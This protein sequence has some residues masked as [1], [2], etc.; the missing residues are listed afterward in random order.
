MSNKSNDRQAL[1]TSS[2]IKT[3]NFNINKNKWKNKK[4]LFAS[5]LFTVILIVSVYFITA[6][7]KDLWPFQ[8]ESSKHSPNKPNIIY[9]LM[10]NL[11][12]TDVGYNGASFVTP[13]IDYLSNNGIKLNYHYA[14]HICSAS[15]SAL[16]TGRY[17]WKTTLNAVIQPYQQLH[18]NINTTTFAEELQKYGFYTLLSGKW[19]VGG[20]K[21]D[22]MPFN[23]GFNESLFF[24]SGFEGYYS[25]SI[26]VP[27]QLIDANANLS[28]Q[29]KNDRNELFGDSFCAYDLFDESMNTIHI[30]QSIYNEQLFADKI[31]KFIDENS[32]N[33][34]T[35]NEP[36]FIY[37]SMPT[38]HSPVTQP[39]IQSELCGHLYSINP[40]RA[41]L[42]NMMQFGDIM[43]SQ[44][45]QKLKQNN[46]YNDTIIMF[47]SDNGPQSI[48]LFG[49][50]GQFG[51][52]LPLRGKIRTAFEG[53]VR[54]SAVIAG[55]YIE[56]I[57]NYTGCSYNGL[58]HLSD[59]FSIIFDMVGIQLE[60][61]LQ[62]ELDAI[63]GLW[64]HMLYECNKKNNNINTNNFESNG[65]NGRNEIVQIN[66]CM[67]GNNNYFVSSWIRR[68]EWKLIVNGSHISSM[69]HCNA[70][71]SESDS[72]YMYFNGSY[73]IIPDQSSY[74]ENEFKN[75][76][77]YSQCYENMSV[78]QRSN[79]SLFQV[80]DI[81]LF[82]IDK[83]A[84]EACNVAANHLDIVDDL[85]TQLQ[86]YS[87]QYF[88]TS[89]E[90]INIDP[91]AVYATI[92]TYDCQY[93]NTVITTVDGYTE[94]VN[95]T[96]FTYIWTEF[97]NLKQNC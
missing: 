54:T 5:L 6:F 96:D 70:I 93:D 23:R 73:S 90:M 62:N 33:Y 36:F 12:F 68:D 11:G 46:I 56:N 51:Q 85:F 22:E 3:N 43:I 97:I 76:L 55:G 9:I 67:E 66:K 79:Q 88:E 48:S 45:I 64:Y 18:L 89:R 37:Y 40:N 84:I 92:Q 60:H 26:C 16:L 30:N 77:F 72:G 69:D 39:P 41:V 25:H 1:L 53:G 4:C 8:S 61:D 80:E 20:Y 59:W 15:R 52:A 28:E 63:D 35:N 94:N 74:F 32:D 47:V 91:L 82:N 86:Q 50:S 10:D 38:P 34:Q 14:E 42:C 83:D 2:A 21:L 58:V 71:E 13:T 27:W 17:A 81:M 7:A 75:E 44:I 49:D 29:L 57:L 78:E 19:H 31:I 24:L 87:E 95:N 65:R